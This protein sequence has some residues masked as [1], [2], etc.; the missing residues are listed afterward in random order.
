MTDDT[1]HYT[2]AYDLALLTSKA[3]ENDVFRSIC[4]AKTISKDQYNF[5]R[6]YN[7]INK[8][9]WKIPNANGVKTGYTGQAGKLY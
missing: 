2:T 3:M 5:T 9:L 1:K 4:G 8:I 7:N 6:E